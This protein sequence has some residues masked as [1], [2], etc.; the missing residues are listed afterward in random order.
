MLQVRVP[1]WRGALPGHLHQRPVPL[2]VPVLAAPVSADGGAAVPALHAVRR[3]A[4]PRLRRPRALPVPGHAA[5][6]PLRLD[7]LAP[8]SLPAGEGA[9]VP[10]LLPLGSKFQVE[11]E[12]IKYFLF[13]NH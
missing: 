3:H 4:P 5:R 9:S 2:L 12:I 10:L 7:D 11:G 1:D 6:A 8:V 13:L